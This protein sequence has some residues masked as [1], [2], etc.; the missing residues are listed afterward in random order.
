MDANSAIAQQGKVRMPQKFLSVVYF[1]GRLIAM[2]ETG[3]RW[4]FDPGFRAETATWRF[5]AEGPTRPNQLATFFHAFP[6]NSA[7]KCGFSGHS[8]PRAHPLRRSCSDG[9]GDIPT[10]FFSL[11]RSLWGTG[12][13]VINPHLMADRKSEDT[14]PAM[15]LTVFG[16]IGRGVL[17]LR[18]WPPHFRDRQ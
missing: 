2:T 16:F 3:D 6:K 15:F 5:L 11:R 17:V 8:G 13:T 7:E 18:V 1:E 10:L 14:T 4:E 12:F 9:S